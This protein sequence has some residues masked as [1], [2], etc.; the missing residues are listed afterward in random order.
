MAAATAVGDKTPIFVTIRKAQKLRC[1]KN[2]KF[3][4]SRYRHQKKRDGWGTV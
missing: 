4:S 1:I 2:E 3:L